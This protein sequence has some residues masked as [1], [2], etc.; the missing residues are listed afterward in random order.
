VG[1]RRRTLVVV[2]ALALALLGAC[3]TP[4]NVSLPVDPAPIGT[5]GM[6]PP[7]GPVIADEPIP[8]VPARPSPGCGRPASGPIDGMR[9]LPVE[10]AN[11]EYRLHVPA[12]LPPTPV[13]LVFSLHGL[14]TNSELQ[15]N[16]TAWN[17]LA[18]REGFIVVYPQGVNNLWNFLPDDANLDLGYLRAVAGA[19][20]AERCV[21]LN[22]TF[23]GGISMGSLTAAALA[24]K[25]PDVFAA[26]SFVAGLQLKPGCASAPAR[27]AIVFWGSKDCVLP[28]FGGTGPCLAIG[29]PGRTQPTA[30][31]PPEK[32]NGFPPVEEVLDAVVAHNGCSPE[33]LAAELTP[34]VLRRAYRSCKGDASVE[35]YFIDGGSH[36]WPGS[37][38]MAGLENGNPN[39]AKGTTSTEIDATELS[40]AFFQRHPLIP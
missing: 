20:Q 5:D 39:P 7:P 33:P 2:G 40:W 9:P 8:G 34:A 26:F 30:P 35:L 38:A 19:V 25:A 37:K 31:V 15:Q 18:D 14:G 11:R 29:G 10:G 1:R 16:I 17:D 32:Q 23:A 24:C 22:R 3:A 27:A 28:Y 13:P 6:R 4:P 12:D 36:S 21:D